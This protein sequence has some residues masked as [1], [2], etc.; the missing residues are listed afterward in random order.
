MLI[1]NSVPM[2]TYQLSIAVEDPTKYY[3]QPMRLASLG[4]RPDGSYNLA[5][6]Q[7]K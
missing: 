3:K 5:K 2:G 1:P 7:L 6:L 4:A